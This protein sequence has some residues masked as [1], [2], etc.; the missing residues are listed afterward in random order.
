MYKIAIQLCPGSF[1]RIN[2]ILA[3]P[4]WSS[5]RIMLGW[6]KFVLFSTVFGTNSTAQELEP[7][8]TIV[9]NEQWTNY[10]EH[11]WAICFTENWTVLF[12][13]FPASRP[14][15]L[16]LPSSQER[17]YRISSQCVMSQQKVHYIY[18]HVLNNKEQQLFNCQWLPVFC[19]CSINLE[20]MLQILAAQVTTGMQTVP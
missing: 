20:T 3:K 12:T 9:N 15:Q 2:A 5:R 6:M 11:T 13:P 18:K 8:I 1:M 19:Q 16:E 10:M 7:R 4:H 14:Q 17:W